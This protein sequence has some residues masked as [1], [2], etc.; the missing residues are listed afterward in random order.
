MRSV[1]VSS[2]DKAAVCRRV[3]FPGGGRC[4]LRWLARDRP[5]WGRAAQLSLTEAPPTPSRFQA[6]RGANAIAGLQP[7]R[8]QARR[9][10][11]V[12]QPAR[13]EV[14]RLAAI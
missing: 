8:H 2:M 5:Q 7:V 4:I 13:S 12:R 14:I 9:A 10:E 3:C 11:A 6:D 1:I